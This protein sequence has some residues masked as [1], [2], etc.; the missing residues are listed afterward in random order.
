MPAACIIPSLRSIRGVE[1][2]RSHKAVAISP[3][4]HSLGGTLATLAAY[5]LAAEF[6]L[7][8]VRCWDAYIGPTRSIC[9][10]IIMPH[11][12]VHLFLSVLNRCQYPAF[13]RPPATISSP[14]QMTGICDSSHVKGA[15]C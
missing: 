11:I 14:L 2:R 15:L 3:T 8:Q 9:A 13:P 5:D 4:G 1:Q 12:C 10:N 6:H 7:D